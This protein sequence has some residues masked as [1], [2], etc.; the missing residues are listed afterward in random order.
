[1]LSLSLT[2]SG[3]EALVAIGVASNFIQLIDFTATLCSRIREYS[4]GSGTP[5]KL[6]AQADRL[7]DLLAVLKSLEQ[8]SS[9]TPLN[10]Q[11]LARCLTQ[12]HD[13]S[14]LLETLKGNTGSRLGN[15]RKAFKSLNKS[16]QIEEL[17][18]VLDGLVNTLSLQLQ[19]DARYVARRLNIVLVNVPF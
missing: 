2:M 9:Q 3:A 8:L 12:A 19:A 10:E 6:I 11:V 16:E 14:D 7:S 18:Q 15:A 1:M 13:L 5:K 4:I 17:Q